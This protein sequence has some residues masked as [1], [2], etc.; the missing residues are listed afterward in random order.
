MYF[1]NNNASYGFPIFSIKYFYIYLLI[2]KFFG[3][4]KFN[5]GI[6]KQNKDVSPFLNDIEIQLNK[7]L[8]TKNISDH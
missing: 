3:K 6:Q 2:S 1:N 7:N 4:F 5:T 8:E